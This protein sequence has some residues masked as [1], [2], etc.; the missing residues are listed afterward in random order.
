MS[1]LGLDNKSHALVIVAHPDDELIWMGGTILM[2]PD[3]KWTIVSLCRGSDSD[4]A[5][6]FKKVCSHLGARGVIHDMEDEGVM[7][8]RDSVPVMRRVLLS[9]LSSKFYNEIATPSD[10]HRGARNDGRGGFT[11]VFTHGYN[12]EYGHPRHKGV[13]RAVKK[14]VDIGELKADRLFYFAYEFPERAFV[15]RAKKSA[16]IYIN[17][18]KD[19]H[20]EKKRIVNELY[21]FT[22]QS[23]EFE[24]CGRVEA[25]S[26][27]NYKSKITNPK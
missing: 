7:N 25:F 26:C 4:R 11:H 27:G 24:S 13:Y 2:Y 15:P 3:A 14:M 19:I 12:G 22:K 16:D 10:V 18:S 20:N 1:D 9:M 5:P 21:G 8:I 23:F 6:K 17:L